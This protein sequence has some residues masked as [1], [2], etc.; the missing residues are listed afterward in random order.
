MAPDDV[1]RVLERTATSVPC[2]SPPSVT[3]DVPAGI[4][5]SNTA[6]CQGGA[7]ANGFFGSGIVDALRAVTR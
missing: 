5:A 3:Y 6:T 4:L 7:R 1:E 2:P